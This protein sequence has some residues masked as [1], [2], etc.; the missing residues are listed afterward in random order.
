MVVQSI[1]ERFFFS[2]DSSDPL[3]VALNSIVTSHFL[4]C[5]LKLTPNL[6]IKD[7]MNLK[8]NNV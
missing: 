1:N 6:I 2:H 8:S 3:S 7:L 4:T 5:K